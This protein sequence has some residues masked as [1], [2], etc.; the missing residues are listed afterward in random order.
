MHVQILLPTAYRLLDSP[1]GSWRGALKVP[2]RGPKLLFFSKVFERHG[3]TEFAKRTGGPA[4]GC[5][6]RCLCG[7][8]TLLYKPA[9]GT[10]T[11]ASTAGRA[12]QWHPNFCF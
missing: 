11:F 5:G 3:H 1:K 4:Q 10:R 12:S 6:S 7:R 2:M 8:R 9:S